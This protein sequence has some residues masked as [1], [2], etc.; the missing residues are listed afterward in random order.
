M[1]VNAWA[2]IVGV[3]LSPETVNEHLEML[4]RWERMKKTELNKKGGR[5]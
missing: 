2:E 5:A 1:I 3:N 4:A